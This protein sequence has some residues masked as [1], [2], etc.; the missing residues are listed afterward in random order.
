M[1][2]LSLDCKEM[3]E[4]EGGLNKSKTLQINISQDNILD[5]ILKKRF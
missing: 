4:G 3:E 2:D 1:Y 5:H